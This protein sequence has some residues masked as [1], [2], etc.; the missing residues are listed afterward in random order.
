M[1]S[2]SVSRIFQG[3]LIQWILIPGL[4]M[5]MVLV[6]IVALN[7]MSIME[8]GI[9]QLSRSLS[10]N[11]D[12][13]IDGAE[14]VLRSVAIMSGGS[15][16][17]SLRSYF[18]GL[19]DRFGQFERLLLLDKNENIIAVAPQGVRGIDFSYPF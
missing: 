18:D 16:D 15:K 6:S 5:T 4:L 1:S 2:H 14:D 19:Q 8:R 9:V 11:V 12:F 10:R 17:E 13:Y 7:Q 3:K